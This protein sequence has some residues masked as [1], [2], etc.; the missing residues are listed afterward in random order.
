MRPINELTLYRYRY[1][2]GYGLLAILSVGLLL[3][4]VGKVPAGFSSA[5][6]ASALASSQITF[7]QS[8]LPSTNTIDLPYHLIQHFSLKLFGLGTLGVRLP[9][10]IFAALGMVF[11]LLVLR[12]WL[13]E[14]VAIAW[15]IL[16]A[17]STWFLMLGRTGAPDIMLVFWTSL[18]LLL[19]TL[20][21]QQSKGYQVWKALLLASIALSFY[22][23]LMAYLFIASALA[24]MSQP[25]LR[26]ILRYAEKTS[27]TLGTILFVALLLPLAWHVWRDPIILRDLLA[28]PAKLPGAITFFRDLGI[29]VGSIIN[30]FQYSIGTIITPL[31]GIPTIA[32]ATVGL[33]RTINDYHSVRSYVLLLWLAVLT[34]VIGLNPNYPHVMFVLVMLLGAIGTQVFFRYWYDLFP[35]NP[36]ARVFGLLPLALL[37]VSTINFNYQRYFTG[38]VYARS[39]VQLYDPNPLLLHDTLASKAYRNQNI[40]LVTTPDRKQLYEIDKA[41]AK[42][43]K[44]TTPSQYAP[45]A[46]ANNII[47]DVGAESQLTN[48]QRAA[49]PKTTSRLL[50]TDRKD[51]ALRFRIY[52]Q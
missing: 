45:D 50:V 34:P 25:H 18:I 20:V 5:E 39:S 37:L 38:V 26:Y 42:N 8:F 2:I 30:P 31:L 44:V 22:T 52:T 47:L 41:I 33:I 11:L 4:F 28:I 21:S 35:R 29:A 15:G 19:A 16:I 6:E 13:Q 3:L 46:S 1:L 10:L 17:T 9:S 24:A 36:Y 23:P 14:N 48:D 51:D 12:R 40:V 7:D 32:F 49:L 27:L 43:L